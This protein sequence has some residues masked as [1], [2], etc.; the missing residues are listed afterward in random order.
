MHFISCAVLWTGQDTDHLDVTYID[1]FRVHCMIHR[2]I[3]W[4]VKPEVMMKQTLLSM[5]SH[6]NRDRRE[7]HVI[8]ISTVSQS[9]CASRS[10]THPVL[11][12]HHNIYVSHTELKP[13]ICQTQMFPLNLNGSEN[14]R[15]SIYEAPQLL[16]FT[17]EVSSWEATYSKWRIRQL[18]AIIC[19]LWWSEI[20]ECQKIRSTTV[21]PASSPAP[22]KQI[23]KLKVTKCTDSLLRCWDYG[24][25]YWNTV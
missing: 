7:I 15:K 19:V 3:A 24:S 25:I 14:V 6:S 8:R 16:L 21:W 22:T 1:H 9:V 18:A 5:I 4:E 10:T 2:F 17:S 23:N 13:S 12:T 20:L 11:R